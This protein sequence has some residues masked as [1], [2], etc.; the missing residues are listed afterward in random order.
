[1]VCL[2]T[3]TAAR[4]G[5]QS[6]EP[7]GGRVCGQDLLR[8]KST[9]CVTFRK[10]PFVTL[11]WRI[12]EKHHAAEAEI[13]GWLVLEARFCD[14]AAGDSADDEERLRARRY[15]VGQR[16]IGRLVRQILFAGEEPQKRASFLSDVIPNRAAQHR[17][18]SLEG[19]E[20]RSLRDFALDV[21]LNLAVDVRQRSKM[22]R[23][24]YLDHDS[25]W[26]S[27]DS[28]PGRSRTI[29]AQLSPESAEA[30]T[31]PPVVPK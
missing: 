16:S 11:S 19:V 2:Q 23:K 21:D 5:V 31:W 9:R 20:H 27:T 1:P 22:R 29:G 4:G 24:Y 7:S 15:C 30:Y 26:T 18:S 25:V 10:S 28:T 14:L 12:V 6:C 13:R 17:I 8:I 3:W